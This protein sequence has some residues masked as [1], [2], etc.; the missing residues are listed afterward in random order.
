MKKNCNWTWMETIDTR[1]E[2]LLKEEEINLLMD[3][4]IDFAEFGDDLGHNAMQY[5]E[6]LN[7][8]SQD[9]L[10]WYNTYFK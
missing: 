8:S 7:V 10:D 1:I 9:L 3:D 2:S 4:L 5:C 6:I